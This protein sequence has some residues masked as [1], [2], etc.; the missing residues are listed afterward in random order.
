VLV[1]DHQPHAG[2][3]APLEAGEEAAPERL[4]LAVAHVQAEDFPGAVG[5]DAGAHDHGHGHDLCGGV[6]DVEVGGVE[7][8]VGELDMPKGAG[9]K[10]ADDLIEPGADPR[11]LGLGDAR[12]DSHRLDQVINRA[13]GDAMHEGLHHHRV[14]RLVD[15]PARLEDRRNERAVAQFRDLV[16][17]QPGLALGLLEALLHAPARAGDPGQ[18]TESGAAG[19]VADVVGDL[20]GIAE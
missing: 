4:V 15:A 19:S 11:H 17:I 8:D 13:G 1:A 12:V 9:A 3:D 18:V 20:G 10:R 7:V 16:V 6:A 14:V 5:R 2:Q